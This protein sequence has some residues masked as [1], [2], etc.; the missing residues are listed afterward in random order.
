MTERNSLSIIVYA[1]ALA[2]KDSRTLAVV[3]GME[4]AI[5]GLRLDWKVSEDGQL[6][7]LPQRDAWLLEGAKNGGFPLVCNG[8]ESYP[9][10]IFGLKTSA[11]SAPGGQPLLDIH[12]K[13]PMGETGIAA[14][15]DVLEGVAEGALAL[16]GEATPFNA[17]VE[18]SR[19]TRDPVRKPGVPPRGLPTL[20]FPDRLRS[21]AIPYHLGWLNYWS[22]A[23]AQAID[24]PDPARDADL[25]S[26]ARRTASGGWIV[27]L[28][29]M[30]LDLDLPEHLDALL[31][32]YERF[33]EIG[34]RSLP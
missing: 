11:R 33:P 20:K 18:I 12:A 5:P 27:R 31:R 32:A 9:V 1:P 28:T 26:R 24:F 7:S 10:T 15:T 34:G 16:W 8:D 25:L 4:R 3:H 2:D 23:A 21:P 30:P 29:E 13:L 17:G 22:A 14:A 19:Q 6:I